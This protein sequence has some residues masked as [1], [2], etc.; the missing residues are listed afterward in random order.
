MGFGKDGRGAIIYDQVSG[1]GIGALAGND[2]V[3]LGGQYDGA[4]IEDF[5]II[6]L[7]YFMG[8]APSQATIIVN[9]PIV[10]GIASGNL[11]AAGIEQALEAFPLDSASINNE[12]TMRPVWLLETF[13][14]PDA[15]SADNATL[16]RKGSVTLRWTFQNPHGWRWFAYNYSASATATGATMS[17]EAKIFGLWIA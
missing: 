11:T 14:M 5:R 8:L 9:G 6:K 1:A 10:I 13:M 16:W 7:D 17:I 15:D 4:L 3:D 2:S 12:L